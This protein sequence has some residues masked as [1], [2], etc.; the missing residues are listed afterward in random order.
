MNNEH[1]FIL[2]IPA[3]SIG[4]L[5]PEAAKVLEAHLGTCE[6]CQSELAA[7]SKV[8][9]NLLLATPPLQPPASLRRSLQNRLTSSHKDSRPISSLS[10]GRMALGIAFLFLLGL[11][12]FTVLQI[13]NLQDQQ[14]KLVR[15]VQTGQTALSM[16]TYSETKTIP[17]DTQVIG[18]TVLVNKE[19]NVVVMIIWNLPSVPENQTYQAWLIDPK[20]NRT[21]AGW[22]RPEA[23]QPFTSQTILS[24]QALSNFTGI[25][26]TVEPAGGSNQPTGQRIFKVDF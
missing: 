11:N 17:I 9:T 26:I 15:Q 18:G 21:N 4:T 20:G 14:A 8:S 10:F 24:K 6:I 22:F 7:Y 5:D 16:L 3:Y 19:R 12:I 2:D 23:G 1:P 25:G 13:F